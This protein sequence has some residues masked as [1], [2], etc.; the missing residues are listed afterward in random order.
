MGTVWRGRDTDTG[1]PVAIKILAEELCEDPD[2]LA[3]FVQERTV[4]IGIRHPNLVAVH[5]MV[6]E[7]RRLALIMDLVSGGDLQRRLRS[8]GV[9]APDAAAGLTVQICA[10]LRAI[11]A[12]GVV[13]RD[14]KPANV[15]LELT[16][17]EPLVR[18]ADFG[19]ARIADRSR[20]TARTSIVGTPSYLAPELIRGEEPF[21]AGDVY[22]LGVTLYELPA[23]RPPFDGGPVLT[24]LHRHLEDA[25]PRPPGIPDSLWAGIEA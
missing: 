6:V 3:R 12:A 16:G 5:D 11:H 15:L 2:V 9:L 1:Q 25:P 23:G 7:R 4:L 17:A 19:V 13:H 20:I 8:E 14:L 10:A 22:A 24:V 18:L 21:A